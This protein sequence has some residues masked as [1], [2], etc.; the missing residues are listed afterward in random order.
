VHCLLEAGLRQMAGCHASW[1]P[2]AQAIQ[3]RP[4]CAFDLM[5]TDSEKMADVVTIDPMMRHPRASSPGYSL[6]RLFADHD[7]WEENH[8]RAASRMARK[9]VVLKIA[10]AR[11]VLPRGLVGHERVTGSASDYLVHECEQ[12]RSPLK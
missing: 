8:L 5:K 3:L 1:S 6:F 4:G 12:E 2:A 10:S 9:R 11:K 7:K